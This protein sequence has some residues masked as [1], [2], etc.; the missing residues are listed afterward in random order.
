[1]RCDLN[2]VVASP[3]LAR[4][5]LPTVHHI[6]HNVVPEDLLFQDGFIGHTDQLT[7]MKDIQGSRRLAACSTGSI[8]ISGECL[9]FRSHLSF[10][11]LSVSSWLAIALF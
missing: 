8:F 11:H 6:M 2:L 3:S 10:R 7:S 1:M 4:L 9:S 5:I